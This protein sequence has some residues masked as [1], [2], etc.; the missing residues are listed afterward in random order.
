VDT[1][2]D[3]P[4][5]RLEV[6]VACAVSVPFGVAAILVLGMATLVLVPGAG[7]VTLIGIA[8]VLDAAAVGGGWLI[9]RGRWPVKGFGA[10][11]VV[12]WGLL[13]LWSGGISAGAGV[14]S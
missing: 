8:V 7:D 13:A 6:G 9:A 4:P 1:T 2:S 14:L 12:G 11:V 5:T 10:G 3:R